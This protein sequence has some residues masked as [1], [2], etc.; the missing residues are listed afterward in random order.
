LVYFG[1]SWNANFWYNSGPF[2]TFVAIWYIFWPF[3]TF[4]PFC[5]LSLEKSGN[6]EPKKHLFALFLRSFQEISLPEKLVTISK[7]LL[8]AKLPIT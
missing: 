5:A 1:R 4:V 7:D 2:G 8:K 3:G 6:P